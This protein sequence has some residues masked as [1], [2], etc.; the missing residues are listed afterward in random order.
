M[1]ITKEDV[2]VAVAA[3]KKLS[4]RGFVQ[5]V[6][7]VAPLTGLDLKKPEHQVDFFLDLPSSLGKKM[8]VCALIGPELQPEAKSACDGM[9]LQEDFPNYGKNKK[10]TKK[11]V[12]QYDFFICQ[13]NIMPQIAQTFGR[14]L[15][16]KGKMPNPK[17]GCVVPPKAALKPLVDKLQSIVHV[18][19]KTVPMVQ[20]KVGNESMSDEALASN[21]VAVYDQ[22]VHTL[23]GGE[24]NVKAAFVKLTMGTPVKIT[25]AA[26]SAAA[27]AKKK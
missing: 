10:L 14:V 5:S 23:P 21:L 25:S 1:A 27:A 20:C 13:A 4:R 22:L 6:D 12:R 18:T 26:K 17:A 11:L 2:A 16:P 9:V 3:A 24:Q 8:K 7:L 19:A 15:G